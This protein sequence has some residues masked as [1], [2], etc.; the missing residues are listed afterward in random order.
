M[1]NARPLPQNIVTAYINIRPIRLVSE[2]FKRESLTGEK[3][4]LYVTNE[5]KNFII[6]NTCAGDAVSTSAMEMANTTYGES[7]Y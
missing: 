5:N 3:R 2:Y 7:A 4:V 6:E 1:V